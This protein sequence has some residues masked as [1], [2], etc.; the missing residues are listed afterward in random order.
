MAQCIAVKGGCERQNEAVG[1]EGPVMPELITYI[2]TDIQRI[3]CDL[4]QSRLVALLGELRNE[5]Q[6]PALT[7]KERRSVFRAT[8]NAALASNAGLVN[9]TIPQL[10]ARAIGIALVR[11]GLSADPG[12]PI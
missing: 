9:P 7:L 3:L 6:G 12:D 2:G 4:C 11:H 5:G 1:P 8:V 10:I